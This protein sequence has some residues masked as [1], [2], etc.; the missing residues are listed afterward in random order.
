MSQ[1]SILDWPSSP[2]SRLALGGLGVNALEVEV[3]IPWNNR[4]AGDAAL[5]VEQ[6]QSA[7]LL[8][9][10]TKDTPLLPAGLL[11]PVIYYPNLANWPNP[12]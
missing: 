6:R 8:P 9:S 7:I 3:V 1:T 10:V 12:P 2:S 11:G 5:P 4:L